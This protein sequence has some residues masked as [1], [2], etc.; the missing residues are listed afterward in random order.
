MSLP[1]LDP[2]QRQAALAKAAQ[3]RRVRADA[4]QR[5]KSGQLSLPQLLSD[6]DGSPPLAKMRVS[7]VLEAMPAYGPI[8]AQRLMGELDIAPSRRVRGLGARQRA[9]LLAAFEPR[10]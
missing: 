4:K 9:A 6:A 10:S 3:A 5:L 8:K 1:E 2:D 7:E